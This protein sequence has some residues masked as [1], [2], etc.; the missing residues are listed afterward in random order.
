[1]NDYYNNNLLIDRNYCYS[2]L[3][4]FN[5]FRFICMTLIQF[6]IPAVLARQS[7]VTS[8]RFRWIRFQPVKMQ[9]CLSETPVVAF[10]LVEHLHDS[11]R[12]III[13]TFLKLINYS[14][15]KWKKSI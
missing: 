3:K 13:I 5:L 12:T 10:S 2:T 1:M 4:I 7:F 6:A 8:F 15:R 11:P 9:M 14:T